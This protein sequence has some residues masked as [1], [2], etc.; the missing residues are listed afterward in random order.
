MKLLRIRVSMK[1]VCV[2]LLITSLLACSTEPQA[3]QY[4]KDTCYTCKM[5]LVD[6]RFG[7]EIVTVKGKVYKFDDINCMV[8]FH[9]SGMERMEE[10]AYRLVIDFAHP[11]TLIDTQHAFFVKT[12][13]VRTPM[14]SQLSAFATEADYKEM[15]KKWKG[16]LL[17]WGE[18]VTEF[19]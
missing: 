11:E 4:G 9:N 18:V 12:D 5:T 8:N 2:I 15:N 10:M 14:G 13:S 16:I 1:I 7:A 6:K 19:K 3:L 17:G